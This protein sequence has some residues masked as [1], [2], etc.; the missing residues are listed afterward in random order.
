MTQVPTEIPQDITIIGIGASAGGLEA[1]QEFLAHLPITLQNVAFIVA[2]HLSPTHKSRLVELL[3]KNTSWKV[4][5]AHHGEVITAQ[6]V[7]ITPPD[8]E[9]E[10]LRNRIKLSKPLNALRPKPSVDVLFESLA[11]HQQSKAI[12]IILSGTG[13]DGTDGVRA[14]KKVGGYTIAQEP[15]TAKYNGMPVSA[16]ES[17]N[18]DWVLS[19]D[20][21][22]EEIYHLLQDPDNLSLRYN[23]ED[24]PSS[25]LQQ[26][27][28]ILSQRTGTDFSNYKPSTVL[29]RLEKRIAAL[30]LKHIDAYLKFLESNPSEVDTLFDTILIGVTSFF[31]DKEA[32]E[33]LE[34]YVGKIVQAKRKT[35][36][37]RIWVVG[38]A[39]GEE[40]YSIAILLHKLLK[41]Y[42][43]ECGVQIFATDIDEKAIMKARKGVY[44]AHTLTEMPK[45]L[46]EQY[47]LQKGNDYELI[48]AIRSMVL[49]S[50]HDITNNPPFLKLDMITCRNLLIYFGTNL[51]KQIMPIF[52]Y[53][54]NPHGYMFLGKSETVG[55]FSNLFS[56]IDAKS[57]IFQQKRS[58]QNIG[59]KVTNFKPVKYNLNSPPNA[60]KKTSTTINSLAELVK[61]TLYHSLENPYVIV[62][63]IG[64]I[65]EIHGSIKDFLALQEGVITTNLIKLANESL[66]IELRAIFTKVVK[67]KRTIRSHVR[68]IKIGDKETYLRMTAT[69]L[70]FTE[71]EAEFF[72]I[73]FEVIDLVGFEWLVATQTPSMEAIQQDNEAKL[74]QDNQRMLELE[75]ELAITKEHLQSYIEE[76]ET[77]NEEL[78]SLNEELQSTNEEL[79]SSNEELET[80]N[81]ELQSTNEEVQIT[82]EEL[83]ASNEELEKTDR[84]LKISESN[85]QALLNNTLKGNCLIDRSYRIVLFNKKL[86][87]I[88]GL[89]SP[90]K[91]NIGELIIDY[92]PPTNLEEFYRDLSNAIT[93]TIIPNKE[94]LFTVNQVNYYLLINFTPILDKNGAV[95]FVSIGILDISLTKGLYI[96]LTDSEKLIQSVFNVAAVGICV[97]DEQGYFVDVNEEYCR[98][99]GYSKEEVIGKHFSMFIPAH[100]KQ[101]AEEL[102]NKVVSNITQPPKEWQVMRKDGR[103]IDI[104]INSILLQ[105]DDGK[106]LTVTS[107]TDITT[108]K[109]HKNLLEKTQEAAHIGGWYLDLATSYNTWTEEVYRIYDAPMDY[110]VNVDNGLLRYEEPDRSI[111]E[112]ALQDVIDKGQSYQLTLRFNS[113]KDQRK[114]VYV[115]CNP[116]VMDD[117]VVKLYGTI[118]DITQRKEAEEKLKE[119][120][121]RFKIMADTAPVLLWIA[122]TSKACFFFNKQ[123]LEFRGKKLDEEIGDGWTKGVHPDDAAHCWETY[124]TAFDKKEKFTMV[125]RLQN[126]NGEY[127]WLLDHGVPRYLPSGEF[128]GYIGSCVD[129]TEQKQQEEALKESRKI[130]KLLADNSYDVIFT[131]DND[132]KTTFVSPSVE[133]MYG[134][135]VEEFLSLSLKD[136]LTSSSLN[137]SMR[138]HQKRAVLEQQNPNQLIYITSELEQVR[139]DGTTFWTEVVTTRMYDENQVAIGFLGITRDI[140][141]RKQ[142][143]EELQKLSL[144]A[145]KTENGII[146]TGND[147][148]IEWVNEGFMKITGYVL[149]EIIGRNPAFLQGEETN[150]EDIVAIREGLESKKPFS[151]EIL[152]YSKQG[153][154]YWINLNITPILNE[155]GEVYK[156][157]AIQNDITEKKQS[158]QQLRTYAEQQRRLTEDLT[159]QNNDLRQF[160]YI[161]SH[162]IRSYVANI[163][164]II[165]LLEFHE[166][167]IQENRAYLAMLQQA[168]NGLDSVIRDL[169]EILDV[170]RPFNKKVEQ[171]QINEVLSEAVGSLQNQLDECGGEITYHL[172]V[173]SI[174]IVKPYFQSVLYNLVSNAIKYRNPDRKLSISISTEQT[175]EKIIIKVADNGLGIDLTTQKDNIFSLYKRFHLHTSGKGLGLF[176]VKTQ[177]EAMGGKIEVESEV[178]VGS[179]FIITLPKN[180]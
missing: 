57:K 54:L 84:L 100:N 134:Y 130:Y 156:F 126:A 88:L 80:S 51:Q 40:A 104:S 140:T 121:V 46:I 125:Y 159:Q 167:S 133:R 52:H 23:Q 179:T 26:I 69:P 149:E 6:T 86:G 55:H 49:F 66:Q 72:M 103:L 116:V 93:N 96:Q 17:G 22:G 94:Y 164:G 102:H 21:I 3:S 162:N 118:Q 131:L 161:L 178:N 180:L 119:S 12:G 120:E 81:E 144:V 42:E 78:Q 31:R 160:S 32:F 50:K 132:L 92:I 107:I 64:D 70:L 75:H 136:L 168:A 11:T 19:P 85:L 108:T 111:L 82:Y 44:P 37:I 124:S 114:W 169:N 74:Q 18:V 138:N 7:Y 79:Q 173:T 2:Q 16:I 67:E 9:I 20:R 15:N 1:L 14:I 71:K 38:C 147:R 53:A 98:I 129:I 112:K 146:I 73:T 172:A 34:E 95:E 10:L 176:M 59:V 4:V 90:K 27:F 62:N 105:L 135:T 152:N 122:D 170:R 25:S 158:E 106:K 145:S 142:Q 128:V 45:E 83:K 58:Q 175:A 28:S 36:T 117:K 110:A 89:L 141:V 13:T 5:E 8:T 153:R 171:V 143:E 63:D 35:E 39:T 30:Q 174:A 115:T 127:R 99:Y 56:T 65:Q 29:R 43:K 101:K 109:E 148:K 166:E 165:N 61:E 137:I 87:E 97:T 163:L 157:V 41:K 155:N 60:V 113:L 47:F 150:P 91:L 33:S 123:W 77:S 151:R 154:K 24:I 48:K 177:I 68:K 76:L 139:K